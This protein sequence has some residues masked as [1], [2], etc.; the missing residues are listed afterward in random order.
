MK[1]L[2]R[3]RRF[4]VTLLE[5]IIAS[6]ILTTVVSSVTILLRSGRDAWEANNNDQARL[7]AAHATVR[8]IV[9]R[10]RQ[11]TSVVAMSGPSDDSGSISVL[12]ESGDTYVYD[13]DSSDDTVDFG[14]TT[15][16][17]VLGENITKLKFTGYEADG[18]TSTTVVGDVQS[19]KVEAEVQLPRATG[20]TKTVTSWAWIRT[21]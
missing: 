18:T 2:D 5:V 15:A 8:H 19:I 12:M 4:G 20:G 9:R 14:V 7:E 10:V 16:A 1:R 17:S 13:H 6:T 11:A 3:K 21:W